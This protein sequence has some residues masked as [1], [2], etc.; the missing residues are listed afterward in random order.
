MVFDTLFLPENLSPGD[1]GFGSWPVGRGILFVIPLGQYAGRTIKQWA[2]TS[3]LQCGCLDLPKSF[4]IQKIR[5]GIYQHQVSSEGFN[6]G[7]MG[8]FLPTSDR[9]W[10]SSKFTLEKMRKVIAEGSLAKYASEDCW[11]D[12]R[13]INEMVFDQKSGGVPLATEDPAGEAFWR[14]RQHE[15]ENPWLI[16]EQEPF[17]MYV[18]F[19]EA[20]NTPMTFVACLEGIMA[21]AIV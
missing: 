14:T 19:P 13:A 15:P 4:L 17:H 1:G 6:P 20:I 21:R 3:M 9:L 10:L 2:H 8:R 18:D 7:E 16:R 5:L 12:A 11:E